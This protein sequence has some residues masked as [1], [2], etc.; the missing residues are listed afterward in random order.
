MAKE[1]AK[2]QRIAKARRDDETTRTAKKIIIKLSKT[3][4]RFTCKGRVQRRAKFEG[5]TT[6]RYGRSALF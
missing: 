3:D 5:Y 2:K 6:R 1:E 4:I